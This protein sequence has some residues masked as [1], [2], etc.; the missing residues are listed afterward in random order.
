MK[1]LKLFLD[2]HVLGGIKQGSATYLKGLYHA[3]ID[4]GYP[5][6]LYVGTHSK[7]LADQYSWLQK[8]AKIVYYRF[9]NRYA[10]LGYE[11][12]AIIN[13]YNI[14]WAH[15]QYI[16]PAHKNCLWITTIYDTLFNQFPNEFSWKYRLPRNLMFPLSAHRSDL[17]TTVSEYSRTKLTDDYRINFDDILV[18]PPGIDKE[19]KQ[20]TY[21][22]CANKNS[23]VYV[24]RFE[25]RKNH[26]FLIKA[27]Y[28]LALDHAGYELV[29][30]GHRALPTPEF[31]AYLEQ[32]PTKRRESYRE[33][34]GISD[35]ELLELYLSS[36]L[37]VYPSKGE[38][39]GLPPI[40]AAALGVPVICSNSTAMR[41]FADHGIEL[42]DPTDFNYFKTIITR[43]LNTEAQTSKLCKIRDK[44][45]SHYSW[46]K[47]ASIFFEEM[48]KRS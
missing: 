10:R 2:G 6:D 16:S 36:A 21:T 7:D 24:S 25:P 4:S 32:L 20:H 38:G 12:P 11:I 17:V 42:F 13:R 5:I 23:I 33:I 34:S 15:F 39:F 35:K 43:Y 47:S 26:I 41:D 1:K 18:L 9:A 29:F 31:D 19:L 27:F 45:I 14:D 44:V 48:Q 30:V 46:E 8:S 40:E 28:D 37:F 22:P 3:L